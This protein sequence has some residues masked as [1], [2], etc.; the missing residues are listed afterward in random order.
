MSEF[1]I[2]EYNHGYNDNEK[3]GN[4]KEWDWLIHLKSGF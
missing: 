4:H 3:Q 2:M 1:Q